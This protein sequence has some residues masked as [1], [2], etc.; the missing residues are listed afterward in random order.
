MYDRPLGPIWTPPLAFIVYY[1][2]CRTLIYFFSF[3][4]LK[5]Q[6]LQIQDP[7]LFKFSIFLKFS[8]F[9]KLKKV[10]GPKKFVIFL[11]FLN[12]VNL[13]NSQ[14]LKSLWAQKKMWIKIE[15]LKRFWGWELPDSSDSGPEAF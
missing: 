7:K 14:N 4:F 8:K 5:L 13:E 11:N 12:F 2:L 10:F 1:L 6:A 9:T 3:S 15:N